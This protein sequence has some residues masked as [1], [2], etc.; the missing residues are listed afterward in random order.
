MENGLDKDTNV[1]PLANK[2]GLEHII[3]LVEDAKVKG[4][5]KVLTGGFQS[6]KFN[7]GFFY[8]PTVLNNVSSKADIMTIEPFGPVAPI[9]KFKDPNDAYEIANNTNFGLAGYVLLHH[10]KMHISLLR[11]LKLEWLALMI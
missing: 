1:G 2:R 8:E 10:C 6:K 4:A 5:K 3:E 9:I 7:K 11:N